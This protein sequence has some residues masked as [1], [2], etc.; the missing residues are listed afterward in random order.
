MMVDNN[1]GSSLFPKNGNDDPHFRIC[2][3]SLPQKKVSTFVEMS[4]QN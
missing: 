1:I 3:D 4:T 2:L